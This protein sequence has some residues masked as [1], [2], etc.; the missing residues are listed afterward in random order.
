MQKIEMKFAFFNLVHIEKLIYILH[1]SVRDD[2]F[3]Y[4]VKRNLNIFS[5][6]FLLKINVKY[7]LKKFKIE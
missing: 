4:E 1:K 3:I 7:F 2:V 6:M 5:L